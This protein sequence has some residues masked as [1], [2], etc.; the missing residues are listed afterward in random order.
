LL[1]RDFSQAAKQRL[2]A[3]AAAASKDENPYQSVDH[4]GFGQFGFRGPR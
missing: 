2:G 1:G 4:G 3:S